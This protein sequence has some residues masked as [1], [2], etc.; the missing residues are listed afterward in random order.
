VAHDAYGQPL[1]ASSAGGAAYDRA[2][3]GLLGWDGAT[4]DFFQTALAA[5]AGLGV[6]HAGVAICHFLEE[7]FAEARAAADA[8]RAA[9]AGQSAREQSHVEAVRRWVTGQ[10]VE[11]E[12]AMREHLAAWPRDVV[13]LQRLYYV[14]FWQGKFPEMLALTRDLVRHYPGESFVLGL[15]AFAL[16][17][18]GRFPEALAVAEVAVSRNP[19]DAW[20]IHALAHTLYEMGASAAGTSLL[21][22]AIHPCTHLGWFRNHLVWHLA[23]MHFAGGDYSRASRISR[24]AFERAPSSIAGNLHDVV[25]MLWR[26]GLVGLDVEARWAPFAAIARERLTRTGLYFHVAHMAMALGGAGDWATASRQVAMLRER[27]AKDHTGLMGEVLV[28]LVEGLHAF[29]GGDHATTIERLAPLRPRL[30]ELGGSRAQR[31][32]FHDTLLEACFR[33]G[34]EARAEQLLAERVARRPDRC[35]L[36]RRARAAHAAS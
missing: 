2:V 6:A 18:A 9:A 1:S 11:A 7:R 26:L 30:V 24:L 8:A 23:L 13:I 3:H 34:D 14:W 15:H 36:T 16:E 21:P 12:Q 20:A 25:S 10:V 33:A 17:E 27:S 35:W 32:V 4:L 31:D 19:R 5:D 28:P 29:A 22:P